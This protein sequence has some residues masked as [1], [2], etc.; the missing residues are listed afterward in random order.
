MFKGVKD[1]I[2]KTAQHQK[3]IA[4][5]IDGPNMMRSEFKIKLDDIQKEL[6]KYGTI[7]I[8]K[9]F[10]NQFASEKLIEAVANLG[11]E[12]IVTIVDADIPMT[13]A[14]VDIIY[15]DSIDALALMTRDAGFQ[16]VLNKAKEHGKETF[17][18]AVN[19]SLSA[20][21]KNTA[22]N[23]IIVGNSEDVE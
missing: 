20:A 10:L 21:L 3:S 5:L 1:K 22:D 7:K 23:V 19:D 12:P 2:R 18:I 17:V 8:A 9:V 11:F 13:V 6:S 16:H 15:N 4:L 14:A